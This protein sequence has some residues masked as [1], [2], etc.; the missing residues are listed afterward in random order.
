MKDTDV[1]GRNLKVCRSQLWEAPRR[2][3]KR[4]EHKLMKGNA[5]PMPDTEDL[6]SQMGD[7]H[8][9]TTLDLLPC[10]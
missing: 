5:Y 10:C 6:I 4:A 8:Y 9:F 2:D 1:Y 7:A 3:Q